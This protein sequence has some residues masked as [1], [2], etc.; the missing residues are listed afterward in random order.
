MLIVKNTE[1]NTMCKNSNTVC[2]NIYTNY[3][4]QLKLF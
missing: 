2:K 4:A 1:N 3:H